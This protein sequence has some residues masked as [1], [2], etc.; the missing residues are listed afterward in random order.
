MVYHQ[1]MA[2][3][4]QI[5]SCA[6]CNRGGFRSLPGPDGKAF[7]PWCGDRVSA[8]AAP[9]PTPEVSVPAPAAPTPGL[10]QVIDRIAKEAPE[11]ALRS[12]REHVAE[13]ERKCEQAESELRKELEKKQEIKRAVMAEMGQVGS[14]LAEAKA[15]LQRK[16]EE[17]R[18]ALTEAGRLKEDL[19]KER[20]RADDLAGERGGLEAK[21][22]AARS[23]EADLDASRKSLKELQ[24]ARDA[25]GRDAL[26]ARSELAKAKEAS[27][28]EVAELRKKLSAGEARVQAL[29]GSGD[30][31]KILKESRLRSEK[32]RAELTE[33]VKTL[34]GEVE[35][36]DQRVRDLQLLVKTLGERLNDLTSR[37]F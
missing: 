9:P 8:S 26:V 34:Q 15:Q 3:A 31:V 18:S 25:A 12:L 11:I 10:D 16:D 20:K 30:E 6:R 7:C 36:R 4:V 22:K 24:E 13:V 17:L 28:A 27:A 21:E 14:Q 37:H 32:E 29:K 23:L 19:G 33:K 5:F 35:K 1:A 2:E